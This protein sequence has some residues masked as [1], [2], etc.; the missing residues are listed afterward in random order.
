[1]Q[2]A[3]KGFGD[4]F[5]IFDAVRSR[6]SISATAVCH[7][8]QDLLTLDEVFSRDDD[9]SCGDVVGGEHP[10]CLPATGDDCE[11]VLA[12]F[13]TGGFHSAHRAD[14]P[15]HDAHYL[16]SAIPLMISWRVTIP[17]N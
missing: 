11:A 4:P 3:R 12:L 7:H 15:L 5:G 13:T 2:V 10:Y 8:R 17:I 9:R 16:P 14:A 6:K 1:M